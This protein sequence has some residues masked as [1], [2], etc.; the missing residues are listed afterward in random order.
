MLRSVKVQYQLTPEDIREGDEIIAHGQHL[1]RWR[2]VLWVAYVIVLTAVF[3]LMNRPG[4]QEPPHPRPSPGRLLVVVGPWVLVFAAIVYWVIR[5]RRKQF[6][7]HQMLQRVQALEA[8]DEGL[9][10]SDGVSRT[11]W[12]WLAFERFAESTNLFLLFLEKKTAVPVP[13]RA[14]TAEQ[15]EAFRGLLERNV[16]KKP[17][18]GFPVVQ[19][20]PLSRGGFEPLEGREHI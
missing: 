8:G 6:E 7:G 10:L 11:D 3:V 12:K 19:P 18:R 2:A 13:K 17:G 15:L 14:F 5:S 9:V 16:G 20:E 4:R 1:G